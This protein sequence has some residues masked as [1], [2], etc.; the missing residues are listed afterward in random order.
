MQCEER[1]VY[2][3]YLNFGNAL[4]IYPNRFVEII[5]ATDFT[6]KLSPRVLYKTVLYSTSDV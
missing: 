1:E 4:Q 6:Q 5:S 3:Y 2:D